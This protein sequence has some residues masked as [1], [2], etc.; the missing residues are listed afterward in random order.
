MSCRGGALCL[1]MAAIAETSTAYSLPRGG[2]G[3]SRC[4]C[5]RI[6]VFNARAEIIK[7]NGCVATPVTLATPA[8]LGANCFSS[9]RLPKLPP[10]FRGET[11]FSSCRLP[12]LPRLPRFF[13]GKTISG[14]CQLPRLPRFSRRKRALVVGGYPGY[15]RHVFGTSNFNSRLLPRL[16]R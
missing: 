2:A 8:V 3:G 9:I 1:T 10:A 12:R 6:R 7:K 4:T 16:P 15:P 13:S 14:S 11:S 5:C